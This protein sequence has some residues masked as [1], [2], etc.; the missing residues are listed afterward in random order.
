M[1]LLLKNGADVNTQDGEY[2]NALQAASYRGRWAIVKLLLDAG[3][4]VNAQGGRYGNAL[5][6]ASGG[7][8]ETIVKLLLENGADAN[9]LQAASIIGVTDSRQPSRRLDTLRPDGSGRGLIS[10]LCYFYFG[11]TPS[12][13]RPAPH[14]H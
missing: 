12:T 7:G 1:K 9:A 3:A 13:R 2:G 11:L 5:H 4:D 6:A 14:P 8:H 10:I